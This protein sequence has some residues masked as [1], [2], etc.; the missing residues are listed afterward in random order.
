[1][2][3]MHAPRSWLVA[4]LAAAVASFVPAHA[5]RGDD[6]PGTGFID[7]YVPA[8]P[9]GPSRAMHTALVMPTTP[10]LLT[11]GEAG[12]PERGRVAFHL[13]RLSDERAYTDL[14]GNTWR[15]DGEEQL[16]TLEVVSPRLCLDVLGRGQRFHLAG[17]VTA[18]TLGY[19][20]FADL[21]D[22]VEDVIGQADAGIKAAHDPY[23]RALTRTDAAG[24]TTDLLDS[25]PVWKARGAIKFPLR[26]TTLF[27]R[28]LS[29]AWSV[30]VGAPAFG[31]RSDSA[32]ES[33][34][35][36]TT[37]A[38]ALPLSERWRL[39]GGF[40][41]ALPGASRTL[42]RF[43]VRHRTLVPGGTLSAEWWPS[44]S[45]AVAL[46]A[47]INGPYTRDGSAPT[48]LTSYY[49]HLGVLWRASERA[50]LHVLF[51]ENPGNLIVTKGTP[52]SRY[53]FFTQRDADFSLTMGGSFDF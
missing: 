45:F 37:L 22:F 33:V 14:P 36:D 42:D 51:A 30:G 26:E 38:W 1:M 2:H 3:A 34:Q 47:S 18:H 4:S 28:T 21:R 12:T 24:A 32:N 52:S 25:T 16:A 48:D 7:R 43:G 44:P 11:D 27:G 6:P 35:L 29:S 41:L 53:S 10:W 50:E 19:A 13:T 5:A 15:F 8:V 17:S 31:G 9:I 20:W 39:T 46:G 49:L 23:G 40:D